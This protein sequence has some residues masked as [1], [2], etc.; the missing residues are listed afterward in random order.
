MSFG[1]SVR[2]CDNA[3]NTVLVTNNVSAT[4]GIG[5]LKKKTV[6]T[7][8]WQRSPLVLILVL[9]YDVF[10]VTIKVR[11]KLYTKDIQH[12]DLVKGGYGLV[13]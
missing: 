1:F 5:K 4:I 9:F 12:M 3:I 2:T 11:Y 7:Q 13:N 6:G 8:I 10:D